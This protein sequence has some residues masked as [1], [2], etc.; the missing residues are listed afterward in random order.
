[1]LLKLCPLWALNSIASGLTSASWVYY[2][3]L[4]KHNVDDGVLG[5]LFFTINL[6][7]AVS[8]LIAS[9]LARRFG[10]IKTMVFTHL[11][12]AIFLALIPVPSENGGTWLA[13]AFAIL[14]NCTASMNQA[15]RQAFLS[16]AV[17]HSERIAVMGILNVVKTL[18]QAVG[19]G[20]SGIIAEK[21][22]GI[23]FITAG[24]MEAVH[25]LVLLWM[26]HEFRARAEEEE[27]E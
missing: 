22:I 27:A 13:M 18:S 11:P 23:A 21:W 9:P 16:M 19:M 17:L 7:A 8:N 12:S 15:P 3:F 6:V 1:M 25:D 24:S 14:R 4:A 5:N 20:F 10:L 26:F 2:F